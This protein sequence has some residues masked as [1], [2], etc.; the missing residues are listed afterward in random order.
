MNHLKK[1]DTD[2]KKYPKSRK[3]NGHCQI[4]SDQTDKI[5]KHA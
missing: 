4:E 3:L 5:Y 1:N 2:L